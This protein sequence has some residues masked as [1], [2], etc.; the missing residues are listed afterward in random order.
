MTKTEKRG[1]QLISLIVVLAQCG[2]KIL[3]LAPPIELAQ[4]FGNGC[5]GEFLLG[6]HLPGSLDTSLIKA[7]LR[8]LNVLML[9]WTALRL[10]QIVS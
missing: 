6:Q 7:Q 1:R 4:G 8:Q 10:H 5:N 2:M 9:L 3:R